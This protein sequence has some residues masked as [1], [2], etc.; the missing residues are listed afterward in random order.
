[1]MEA[2]IASRVEEHGQEIARQGARQGAM[3][4]S[5]ASL[6]KS[7][8]TASETANENHQALR[9]SVDRNHRELREAMSSNQSATR[10]DT[11]RTLGAVGGVVTI[12]IALSSLIMSLTVT[13]IKADVS[14]GREHMAALSNHVEHIAVNLTESSARSEEQSKTNRLVSQESFNHITTWNTYMSTYIQQ[15]RGKAADNAERLSKLE[16]WC[17]AIK[18]K[19]KRVDERGSSRWIRGKPGN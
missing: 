11:F 13:P 7:V 18:D 14:K 19:V 6:A 3:E 15:N 4:A 9:D 2:E 17:E 12:M 5:M 10:P 1:M 8:E 16:S